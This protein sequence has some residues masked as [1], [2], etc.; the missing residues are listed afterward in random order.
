MFDRSKNR[1]RGITALSV[2]FLIGAIISFTATVSLLLPA[3]LIEPMWRLNP[4]AHTSLARIGV[5][6]IVLLV[7]SFR[8][9]PD[10][11]RWIVAR[12]A[13]GSPSSLSSS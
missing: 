2:F 5:W 12:R 8:L 11:G 9:L 6:A 7:S 13:M 10:H 4:R 1:P 3:S